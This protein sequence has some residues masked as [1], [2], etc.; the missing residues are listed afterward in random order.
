MWAVDANDFLIGAYSQYQIRYAGSNYAANFDSLGVYLNNAGYNATIYSLTSGSEDSLSTILQKLHESDIKSMLHD[1]TWSPGGGR[2][3]VGSTTFGNRLQIEAEYQL[4]TEVVNG[5]TIFVVDDLSTY[6]QTLC[7]ESYDYVT[8]HEVGISIEEPIGH[9]YSNDNAWLCDSSQG[10]TAGKALS[11]PRKRWK[12]AGESWPSLLSKDIV[13]YNAAIISS[14]YPNPFNPS[15]TITYSIP[16]DGL[17]RIGIYNIKGQ[18]VMELCK[19]EM[20]RGHH[21]VL[22]DGKDANQRNVSSG[23]YF[24]KLQASGFSST[25]KIMLMK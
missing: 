24:V 3:G 22:W 16:K 19:S 4:K 23:I 11:Y 6:N 13:F 14:T 8:K 9:Q 1:N 15:T 5:N 12:P 20:L 10:H 7:M 25:R 21:K 17:V 2:L 18:K